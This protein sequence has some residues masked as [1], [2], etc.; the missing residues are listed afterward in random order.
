MLQAGGWTPTRLWTD[1]CGDFLLVMADATERR[2][3]P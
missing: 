1:P 2:S 3:A